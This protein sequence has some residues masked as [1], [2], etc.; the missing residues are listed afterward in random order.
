MYYVDCKQEQSLSSLSLSQNLQV[1]W[2][3][4]LLQGFSINACLWSFLLNILSDVLL[5]FS[6]SLTS[7]PLW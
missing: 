6:F 3:M 1:P 5:H 7:V 4:G 2:H